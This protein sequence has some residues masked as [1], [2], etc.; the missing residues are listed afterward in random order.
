M[1][2]V[3]GSSFN[4]V[5]RF[6]K[7]AKLFGNT[8]RSSQPTQNNQ[9]V[10]DNKRQFL[11]RLAEADQVVTLGTRQGATHLAALV[12][13]VKRNRLRNA[14]LPGQENS[15]GMLILANTKEQTAEIYSQIARSDPERL[16]KVSRL[17]SISFIAPRLEVDGVLNKQSI[18]RVNEQSVSNLIKVA[19]KDDLDILIATPLQ[20]SILSPLSK[21]F[22]PLFAVLEDFDLLF[23]GPDRLT[24]RVLTSLDPDTKQVW[25]SR[26]VAPDIPSNAV[27]WLH[28]LNIQPLDKDAKLSEGDIKYTCGSHKNKLGK[29]VEIIKKNGKKRGVVFCKDAAEVGEIGQ[30]LTRNQVKTAYLIASHQTPPPLWNIM[31]FMTNRAQVLLCEE[32]A[33]K[34]V[35]AL[36]AEYSL[37]LH[38]PSD[39]QAEFYRRRA[40]SD[41]TPTIKLIEV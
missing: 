26:H 7:L 14:D 36:D 6:V 5:K 39:K 37:W 15:L 19:E 40:V 8:M 34:S 21:V 24:E 16:L 22:K 33:L 35:D 4:V 10:D 2:I 3:Y 18:H 1:N 30:L 25:A 20:L 11:D 31:N 38:E 27:R 12:E 41:S 9:L 17:G 32:K 23:D 28:D 13:L 29:V